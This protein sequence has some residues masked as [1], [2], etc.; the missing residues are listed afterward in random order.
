[1]KNTF[2][3]LFILMLIASN[4]CLS[5]SNDEVFNEIS[6]EKF[7]ELIIHNDNVI[8]LDV[9][10]HKEYQESHLEN[11]VNI[12]MLKGDFLD[13]ITKLDQSK[14]YLVY[15]KV[16]VRSAKA[17]K[18]LYN[19]GFGNVYHLKGGIQDWIDKGYP[20]VK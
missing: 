9:R 7:R 15:C 20:V 1:M 13:N 10:T 3:C 16:G 6:S 4:T 11:S 8:I 19:S 17:S 12:D 14:I 2:G 18:I 5:Q